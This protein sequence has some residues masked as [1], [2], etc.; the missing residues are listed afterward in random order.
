MFMKISNGGWRTRRRCRGWLVCGLCVLAGL[1]AALGRLARSGTQARAAEDTVVVATTHE[2]ATLHPIF[3]IGG[4][5]TVEILGALFEPL[6]VFD[7]HHRLIPAL[8]IEIPTEAN[9]GIR[10][11]PEAE[12][13]AR[14]GQMESIWHLRP[15]ACWSDGVSVTADDFIFTYELIRHPDVPAV[16]RELEDRIAGM[17]ARDGSRTLVVVW[18]RPYAFAH[19]GHRHLLVPRHVEER[20]FRQ[21]ADKKEY[22]RTP[23]NRH[24]TGNGPYQVASWAFGRHLVLERQPFWHGPAPA[25]ERIVYRFIPEGETILANLDTG[26]LGAVSP[27]ALDHDLAQEFAERARA[28]GDGRYIVDYRPGLWWMHIDFNT[29]NVITEDK[30]MRQALTLGL[31]RDS[32][33][34]LLFP[35]QPVRIDTWLPPLHP[36][37]NGPDLRRYPYDPER[38]RALLDEMGWHEGPGGVRTRAGEALRLTL[39]FPAGEALND[40]IAQMVKED[41]R[42]LGVVLYLR[43]LDAK[44]FDESSAENRAY[45]GLSLYPWIMDPS[46]DG[47]TFWTSSNIPTDANPTG[48]NACRWRN[49]RSDVLLEEASQALDPERRRRLLWEQQAIWSDELPAIPLFFQAEIS[50]HHH[51]LQGWRPT[52]TDTPVSWNCYEWRWE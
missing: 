46:A 44:K 42:R 31:D 1:A 52:G 35:G 6:T 12:A 25:V 20:W 50:V 34:A 8:A 37:A 15:D 48:Q 30:R 41:W 27:V 5:A 49:A 21:L 26:R 33:C 45:Q 13:Q 51:R 29:E 43:P 47:I 16:S 2:P 17:E 36:G 10:L 9:G 40:R 22:E 3:G 32:M 14:G 23:F 38:A 7:D 39:T 19:E 18:K 24:P 28:R 4:L 11:L